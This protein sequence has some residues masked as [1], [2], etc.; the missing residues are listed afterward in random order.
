MWYSIIYTQ[1]S[2]QYFALQPN[3]QL[4]VWVPFFLGHYHIYFL[5]NSKRQKKFS[6]LTMV[7]KMLRQTETS[8]EDAVRL[9]MKQ[10]AQLA[11]A[12]QMP[13]GCSAWMPWRV[14]TSGSRVRW[15]PDD[16]KPHMMLQT[17][18]L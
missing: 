15:A 3:L 9:T 7:Q 13:S 14:P 11:D 2:T 17:L 12:L 6:G 16:P 1:H 5:F 8:L 18:P 10:W 4:R